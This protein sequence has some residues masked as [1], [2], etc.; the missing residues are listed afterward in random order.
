LAENVDYL[1]KLKEI[2]KRV[3]VLI[4]V[5]GSELKGLKESENVARIDHLQH[6]E[7]V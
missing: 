6:A 7:L 3:K 4:E 1:L 5:Q 2:Y